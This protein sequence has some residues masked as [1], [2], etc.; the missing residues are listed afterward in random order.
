MVSLEL[1]IKFGV[2]LGHK[3]GVKFGVRFGVKHEVQFILKRSE[4]T[5]KTMKIHVETLK[6]E[7]WRVLGTSWDNFEAILG[8]LWRQFAR[9]G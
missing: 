1:G 5:K 7:S 6:I 2:K 4:L 8:T 9:L 3:L